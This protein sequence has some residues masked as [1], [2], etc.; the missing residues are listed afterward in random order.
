MKKWQSLLVITILLA[1]LAFAAWQWGQTFLIWLGAK[2]ALVQSLDS[3]V[4]LISAFFSLISGIFTF[5][6]L[7]G[8]K[9]MFPTPEPAPTSNINTGGGGY[10]GGGVQTSGGDFVGRDQKVIAKEGGLAAGGDIH[11]DIKEVVIEEVARQV[12]AGTKP[13]LDEKTLKA[14][15]EAYLKYILDLHTFLTM[16]GMGPAE[17][18]PLQLKLLDLYVPLKARREVPKGETWERS[19]K[20]AGRQAAADDPEALRLGEPEP[21]L[22]ILKAK[23]SV[24][25]LGDP[26]S[27]KTTFLKFLA[28]KLARGEGAELGLGER[29]PIL[30]PLAA[31]ANAL[32]EKNVRLDDFIVG[33]FDGIGCDF[34]LKSML[35]K[36]LAAGKALILLDGLDEIKDLSLRNTVVE[37]VINFYASH[38]APGNKFVL[39]SRVVGYR[40]VRSVAEGM[41]ECT[42]V[43]FDDAEI[44]DFITRWTVTLE[45][46]AQGDS[47]VACRFAELERREL[48]DAMQTNTGV[49]LLA[50]NPLL[51]TILALMK[52]KGVTLPERRV[53][54]YDQ[55][56]TTLLSTWNRAR[57]LSGRAPGRDLDEVQTRRVL[58][59][60]ALWMHQ[61]NPG[62]GLVRR[63]DLHRKL[64]ELFTARNAPDPE[65]AARQFLLDV[66]EYA[67]LLLE[68]GPEEYGFIHLTFEEYLAAVALAFLAQGEAAPVIEILTPHI[69]EQA[70]REVA[71]LVVSYL[72]II[73]NLPKVA[74]QVAE[75]LAAVPN[76]APAEA[77]VLAGESVLDAWP[78]G[79]TQASKDRVVEALVPAMQDPAAKPDLRRRAG[80][81]LGRL[82]WQP[83][84]LDE[85]VEIGPGKFLYG[86]KKE[87]REIK[88]RYWM[89]KY[90]VTN[91]QYA[92]FIKAGGYKNKDWWSQDGWDWRTSKGCLQPVYWDDRA[93]SNSIFPVVGVTWFEAEAYCRWLNQQPLGMEIPKG[94]CVRLPNEEEWERAARFTDGREY[95]WNAG[96]APK[97]TNTGESKLKATTAVCTYPLGKSQEGVWDLSGNVWEW[98]ADWYRRGEN[99]A[100]RGGSWDLNSRDA[101]CAY[102]SGGVPDDFY[103][104]IGFRCVV[105][106]AISES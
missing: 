41:A 42:L 68:R 45:K 20:L 65:A 48:M 25:I 17:N 63:P 14:A 62:V 46:Q 87:E 31:Y 95:P 76:A 16:K 59:P 22:G 44:G 18:V 64:E 21:V 105:S 71:L 28:L 5:L 61:V 54:L 58:A 13:G 70:W 98:S 99:R 84:D 43:D 86:E 67:A 40:A 4:A 7:R 1:A 51:L 75:G 26:G 92:R 77:A 94:Y 36:A 79:V 47:Q 103:D 52:R 37:R 101:R 66:R 106:L 82:G 6:S 32:Q 104:D 97:F 35:A 72:G 89:A 102:R 78:D 93:Y 53:Q 74:G 12:W 100:L 55:Y 34:P 60:L 73:Q 80:L 33:Y 49:R 24:I 23:D 50:A 11:I 8:Q 90:P 29:L 57:S 91:L 15:T 69:G 39:T 83:D 85:F 30:L 96:F 10:V 19:L 88:Q 3:F 38:R 9:T 81:A 2:G 27:G 56:V